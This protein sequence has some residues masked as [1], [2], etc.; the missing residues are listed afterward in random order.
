MQSARSPQASRA[1][2]P[3]TT[4]RDFNVSSASRFDDPVWD[5]DGWR[6]GSNGRTVFRW[7]WDFELLDGSRF[8][9]EKWRPLAL[10][11]KRYLL[12]LHNDPPLGRK[13][14]R[15][16]TQGSRYQ[17]LRVLI[18][19]MDGENLRSF[20]DIDQ[21]TA[22][23]FLEDVARR[24]GRKSR[25]LAPSTIF[26]YSTLL[27]TL[28]L[29]GPKIGGGILSDPFPG[30][31][32]N[33]A[34]GGGRLAKGTSPH[35]PDEI[36]VL[37]I[38]A[39]VRLIGTPADDVI[40][41]RNA[42]Q[43]TYDDFIHRGLSQTKA[44]IAT[45]K[46]IEGYAFSTLEDE[47][48]P[49]REVLPASTKEV[50]QLVDR[51][52]DACFIVIV[53]LAGLRISEILNLTPGCI[54]EMPS[55]DGSE[56]FSYIEG[57]IFKTAP[58]KE[59]AP[60]LWIAPEPVVRA[61]MVM[62]QISEPYRR[63]SRREELFQTMSSSG[64]IGPKAAI[65]TPT[66]VTWNNRLSR[67]FAP[68]IHLPCYKGEAWRISSHQGRKTFARFVGKRDRTGLHAL[69]KHFG[70]IT[71]VMTD[72]GYVGTDFVLDE[73]VD[74][75]TLHETHDALEALLTSR[76]LAGPAGRTIAARSP[77]RGR[78]IDKEV[79]SYAT[80]VLKETDMRLGVCDWGFCV[81]R[82]ETAA[83]RGGEKGPNPT[84][85]TESVCLGC[86]NF[87][88]TDR[89]VSFWEAR[90]ARNMALLK[91][92]DLDPVTRDLAQTRVEETRRLLEEL[93]HD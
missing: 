66:T 64:L 4:N 7:R 23:R 55:A 83:C 27:K 32:P 69:Q 41:L 8:T 15:A 33:Q 72:E 75:Q 26:N 46:Q 19:W 73:L 93:R 68:F 81:Y 84:L 86:K 85:R 54:T 42:A 17:Q 63:L 5:M 25:G 9:D 88:V 6:P 53:Y 58:H 31:N 47:D 90:L 62:E 40:A 80:W 1:V 92:D 52:V 38:S 18:A 76:R 3:E 30:Q 89:H 14:V 56:S 82:R 87:S 50:R 24:P 78:T 21:D 45:G 22:A 65:A 49:W 48:L 36:A 60:H 34:I 74:R 13:P 71:R 35:T 67:L 70:H 43:Q 16:S 37:L 12:S 10:T 77:F 39:A 57:R 11:A 20:A 51:I 79:S 44:G 91:R 61:I 29:Q 28:Y 2:G 59:G